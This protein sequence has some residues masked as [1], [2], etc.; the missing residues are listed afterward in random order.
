VNLTR[1]KIDPRQLEGPLSQMAEE[2]VS[3]EGCEHCLGQNLTVYIDEVERTKISGRY[4]CHDC[5][6]DGTFSAQHNVIDVYEASVKKFQKDL[7][8]IFSG[9]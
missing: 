3:L 2:T 7:Q 1:F 5:N 8:K 9:R 4:Y 6:Q